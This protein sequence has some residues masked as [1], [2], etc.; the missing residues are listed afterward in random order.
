VIRKAYLSRDRNLAL[1]NVHL[2]QIIQ[3]RASPS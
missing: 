2:A 3:K 1:Q